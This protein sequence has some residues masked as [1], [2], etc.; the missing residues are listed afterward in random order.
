M[1]KSNYMEE[2]RIFKY[3][4]EAIGHWISKQKSKQQKPL[5]LSLIPFTEIN[6]KW[7]V[8]LNVNIKL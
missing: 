6:A 4:A 7:F 5:N 8:D 3:S 1:Y 2:R